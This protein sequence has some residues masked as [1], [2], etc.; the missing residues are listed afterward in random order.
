MIGPFGWW[1]NVVA[2]L[3]FFCN[4][5]RDGGITPHFH[6]ELDDQKWDLSGKHEEFS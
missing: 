2:T 6:P 5:I 4:R 3:L 1:V